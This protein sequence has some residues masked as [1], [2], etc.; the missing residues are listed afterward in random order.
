MPVVPVLSFAILCRVA[1][2]LVGRW[3]APWS[4]ARPLGA[5]WVE[6]ATVVLAITSG[7]AGVPWAVWAVFSE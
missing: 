7:A 4:V 6:G 3:A 1:A 5:A 2:S